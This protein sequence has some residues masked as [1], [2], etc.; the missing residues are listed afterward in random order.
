MK[1]IVA[2][3]LYALFFLVC[4]LG[5]GTDEKN[6]RSFYFYPDQIQKEIIQS[7]RFSIPKKKSY[8][9]SF[10]GNV[11]LFTLVFVITGVLTKEND[12]WYFLLLGEG[13]NLFDFV[14]IDLLWWQHSKRIRFTGIGEASDYL[15]VKKH[16][17]AF[18]RA[19]PMFALAAL[20]S[21]VIIQF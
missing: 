14:A 11:L 18:G 12:F 20:L 5:T 15:G 10:V 3:I 16:L 21:T 9:L 17:A 2:F 4:Y 19:I 13:L 1:M 8:G 7:G 6:I